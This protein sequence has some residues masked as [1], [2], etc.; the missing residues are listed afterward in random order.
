[1]LSTWPTIPSACNSSWR[2]VGADVC[3]IRGVKV[4][5]KPEL[6]PSSVV[7]HSVDLVGR[8][9]HRLVVAASPSRRAAPFE[10]HEDVAWAD[11]IARPRGVHAKLELRG[12]R[13][14]QDA[15]AVPH[16][17]QNGGVLRLHQIEI[18]HHVGLDD[19]GQKPVPVDVV[20]VI[21]VPGEQVLF[22]VPQPFHPNTIARG[23]HEV[24]DVVA[25]RQD[26][27]KGL[28]RRHVG[29]DD[30]F[31]G[32]LACRPPMEIGSGLVGLVGVM[33]GG[34]RVIERSLNFGRVPTAPNTTNKGEGGDHGRSRDDDWRSHGGSPALPRRRRVPG[35]CK[36][37]WD[38]CGSR[39]FAKR[40]ERPSAGLRLFYSAGDPAQWPSP[41]WFAGE[42]V[43]ASRRGVNRCR[44]GHRT[45]RALLNLQ[46]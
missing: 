27:T 25:V 35:R 4:V 41:C 29:A 44:H 1:M 9:R 12:Q 26:V 6:G 19:E 30:E 36:P 7:E 31:G 43:R 8:A 42:S 28:P 37:T 16:G 17:N 46:T 32:T 20:G 10:M 38:S 33:S 2:I 13:V 45:Q 11:D 3:E 34:W 40:W 18:Q 22:V 5:G 23:A 21:A 15:N 24:A 39:L 14:V